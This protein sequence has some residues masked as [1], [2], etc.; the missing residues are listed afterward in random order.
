M[1]RPVNIVYVA[2][3][4]AAVLPM[5]VHNLQRAIHQQRYLARGLDYLA[6]LFPRHRGL[7]FSHILAWQRHVLFPRNY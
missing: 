6:P 2:C 7:W 4:I 3:V 5:K 1:V